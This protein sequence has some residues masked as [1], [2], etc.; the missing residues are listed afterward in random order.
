MKKILFLC[1]LAWVTVTNGQTSELV[2]NS[3]TG[4]YKIIGD[5]I[6]S[7]FNWG[8]SFSVGGTLSNSS[9]KKSLIVGLSY[10]NCKTSNDFNDFQIRLNYLRG[11]IGVKHHSNDGIAS[12]SI[13]GYGAYLISKNISSNDARKSSDV[14]TYFNRLDLGLSGQI[15]FRLWSELRSNTFENL[16]LSVRYDYGVLNLVSRF[17]KHLSS[18]GNWLRNTV[19]QIG[20]SISL[21]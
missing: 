16:A 5:N 12:L 1:L 18:E 7:E 3:M 21:K 9:K 14:S 17:S 13:S 2:I 11:Q 8:N 4:I 19:L 6:T 10:L 20:L 15:N